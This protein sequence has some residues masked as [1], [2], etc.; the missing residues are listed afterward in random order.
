MES[1][2]V[3]AKRIKELKGMVLVQ[4]HDGENPRRNWVVP[5]MIKGENDDG[6]ILVS[7]PEVGVQYGMDFS[8]I[9][10]M[11]ATPS[12]LDREL[13]RMNIWT[14]DDVRARPN[15]VRAAIQAAYGV[16]F[17]ALMQAVKSYE[18]STEVMS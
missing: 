10:E 16:D 15:D 9:F 2:L 14:A 18:K 6:T 5:V 3:P 7:N 12:D 8:K 13:K 1:K 11:E 17:S 4:W